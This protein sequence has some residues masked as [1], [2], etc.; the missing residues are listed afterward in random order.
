MVEKRNV[1]ALATALLSCLSLGLAFG[2]D[3]RLYARLAEHNVRQRLFARTQEDAISAPKTYLKPLEWGDV[4]FVH[5]TDTHGWLAGH[6]QE[7]NYGGDW[8][9]FVAFNEHMAEEADKRNV[10]LL[11]IET[12]DRHDGSGLSDATSIRGTESNRILSTAKFDIITIGNHELYRDDVAQNDIDVLGAV[13]G[14]NYIASNIDVKQDDRW[15]PAGQRY[16]YFRTKNRRIRVMAFSF[17]FNFEKTGNLTRVTKVEE[18]VKQDWFQYA[19]RRPDI[20]LFVL[21]CH[22]PVRGYSEFDTIVREIRNVNRNTPI[23]GFGGHSH[24]RDYRI[25]DENAV[26]LESGRYLETI[27]WSSITFPEQGQTKSQFSRR[28]IDFSPVNLAFHTNTSLDAS[29][30]RPFYTKT[31]EEIT[32][33]IRRTRVQ[34]DLTLVVGEPSRSY[35]IDRAPYPSENSLLS[36]MSKEVL[37][38]LWGDVGRDKLPRYIILPSSNVRFDLFNQTFTIENAYTICPFDRPWHYVS[39]VPIKVAS[40][41]TAV[42]NERPATTK[43]HKRAPYS[44]RESSLYMPAV[45]EFLEGYTTTDDAGRDGDDTIHLQEKHY[46]QPLFIESA[47]NIAEDTRT[48]D[49]IFPDQLWAQIEPILRMNQVKTKPQSYGGDLLRDILIRCVDENC[50]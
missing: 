33:D 45:S 38:R 37:P 7:P 4:N 14:D 27:G 25:F 36:L 22:I 11:L 12:G 9:D 43:V 8:G 2:D 42:L 17:L 1:H 13:Y 16:R 30:E 20:D 47:Q 48:A 21:A 49:V 15:V 19:I 3:D 44:R 5:V 39:D 10:D 41:L 46:L 34:L 26:A 31:S 23:H 29:A 24:I 35:Y 32:K 50:A 18:A 6:L 28:Y 40:K